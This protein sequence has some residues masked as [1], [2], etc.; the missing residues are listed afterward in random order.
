MVE[1]RPRSTRSR[2]RV[3]DMEL[4]MEQEK[5]ERRTWRIE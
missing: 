3:R 1:M 5:N 2:V 4:G